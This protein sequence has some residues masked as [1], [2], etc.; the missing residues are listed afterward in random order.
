MMNSVVEHTADT[1]QSNTDQ[2]SNLRF[3]F[4]DDDILHSIHYKVDK[5]INWEIEEKK[6]DLHLK[7]DKVCEFDDDFYCWEH[8]LKF[9]KKNNWNVTDL[10][11]IM[12][13]ARERFYKCCGY[14]WSPLTYRCPPF[15]DCLMEWN[16]ILDALNKKNIILNISLKN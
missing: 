2:N 3:D 13:W 12:M 6:V 7:Y 10:T 11:F 16:E 15:P 14:R 4:I 5:L 1:A 9:A 8:M